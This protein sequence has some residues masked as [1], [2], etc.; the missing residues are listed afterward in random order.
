MDHAVLVANTYK[1]IDDKNKADAAERNRKYLEKIA[2]QERVAREKEK[3]EYEKLIADI[4]AIRAKRMRVNVDPIGSDG[5][6]AKEREKVLKEE[7]ERREYF[8]KKMDAITKK[9]QPQMQA[10]MLANT[11]STLEKQF[12]LKQDAAKKENKV[13]AWLNSEKK[14]KL[15]DNLMATKAALNIAGNLVDEGSA[16]AKA[17]AIAQTGIDTYQSATAAYKAVVGI[18]VVGPFL[19]PVAAAAAI[20]AGLMSVR[21]IL[22]T[23]VPKMGDGSAGGGAGG[24]APSIEAPTVAG[25]SAPDINMGG[26][27]NPTSQIAGTLAAASGKPIKAFVV[28]TDMS[29]Q[30]ALDRRTSRS[31]TLSGGY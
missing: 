4:E 20:A 5:M 31:A 1:A 12:G 16:A 2:E 29:S 13:D 15:D 23:E 22:S 17:I 19:A 14:K 30:Q 28:S 18:P 9:M 3:K 24:S 26:G 25:F 8:Q 10:F 27:Q 11:R 7:A 21:K 6:T